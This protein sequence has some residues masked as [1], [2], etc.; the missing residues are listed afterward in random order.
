MNPFRCH[1]I[2]ETPTTWQTAEVDTHR[3]SVV[4]DEKINS[5][6]K[7]A[8]TPSTE[9]ARRS[10]LGQ[11]YLDWS[12]WPVVRDLGPTPAPGKP[13]LNLAPP[14]TWSSVQFSDL[15]FAY[16]YIDNSMVGA[17]EKSLSQMLVR[18]PL[19]GWV[20]VVDGRE[21]AGQFLNGREQK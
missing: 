18:S 6:L 13:G 5:L 4:S 12:Q 11:V 14:E 21:E 8:T 9:V 2:L 15:R 10:Q 16:S 3:Q 17:P 1:A 20:Y 19:T 7:P